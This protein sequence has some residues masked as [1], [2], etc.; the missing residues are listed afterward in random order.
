MIKGVAERVVK[1]TVIARVAGRI[2]TV[3]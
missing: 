1:E 3:R 2:I